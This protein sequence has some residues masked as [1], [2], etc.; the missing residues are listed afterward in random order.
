MTSTPV[1]NI[2]VGDTITFG[3]GSMNVTQNVVTEIAETMTTFGNA[4]TITLD[5]GYV[6]HRIITGEWFEVT[7]ATAA[8]QRLADAAAGA[9][10]NAWDS[11][12]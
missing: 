6:C 10:A 12:R 7:K 5:D 8:G 3:L 1:Y 11:K 9:Y 4:Y 2:E